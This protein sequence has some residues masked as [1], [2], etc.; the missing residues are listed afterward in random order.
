M[1]EEFKL[2]RTPK[3]CFV[4]VVLIWLHWIIS[5]V[6]AATQEEDYPALFGIVNL[7]M[8][9]LMMPLFVNIFEHYQVKFYWG[10]HKSVPWLILSII[11]FLAP[12]VWLFNLIFCKKRLLQ[13]IVGKIYIG[14]VILY[15]IISIVV[16][17]ESALIFPMVL[18]MVLFLLAGTVIMV[19]FQYE[20]MES[21]ARNL[22]EINRMQQLGPREMSNL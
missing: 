6:I 12:L 15:D 9:F 20:K 10:A 16:M 18:T 17:I 2:K 7:I 11:F 1:Y 13:D 4:G 3:I 8:S 5:I 21:K 14:I 19:P 22:D